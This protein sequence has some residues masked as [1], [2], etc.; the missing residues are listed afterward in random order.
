[1]NKL[2]LVE[3]IEYSYDSKSECID[4][5]QAEILGLY[6]TEDEYKKRIEK[7]ISNYTLVSKTKLEITRDEEL[8]EDCMDVV[9]IVSEEARVTIIVTAVSICDSKKLVESM[10]EILSNERIR[11]VIGKN[12]SLVCE[13][14]EPKKIYGNWDNYI[15]KMGRIGNE[16]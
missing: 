3:L 2:Y 9:D 14:L 13:E 8:V 12:A 5:E 4:Q 15:Q 7:E 16:I 1:M 11:S 6:T 10:L